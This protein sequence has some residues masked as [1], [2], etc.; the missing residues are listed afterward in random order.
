VICDQYPSASPSPQGPRGRR[1]QCLLKGCGQWFCAAYPQS[2]YC[3]DTCRQQARRWR[4]WQSSRRWRASEQ[5]RDHRRQQAQRYRQRRV[6]LVAA[7]RTK[8]SQPAQPAEQQPGSIAEREGQRP[9][10]ICQDWD[11]QPCQRPGCYVLFPVQARSPKQ[12]FCCAACRRALRRVLDREA[13]W[14][15]RRRRRF[16]PCRSRGRPPPRA[17]F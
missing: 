1:R 17:R 11:G 16:G 12:R 14:R 8:P 15:R 7:R 9:A 4:R 2:R 10:T 13:K 6:A 3:S 5:G